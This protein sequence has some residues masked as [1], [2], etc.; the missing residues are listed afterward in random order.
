MLQAAEIRKDAVDDI[1]ASRAQFEQDAYNRYMDDLALKRD[2]YDIARGRMVDDYSLRSGVNASDKQDFYNAQEFDRAMQATD[3]ELE[4]ARF[5]DEIYRT[6]APGYAE[7]EYGDAV[8]NYK[9]SEQ[10]APILAQLEVSNELMRFV[11][12]RE[13]LRA[14]LVQSGYTSSQ[15]DAVMNEVDAYNYY[16]NG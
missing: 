15:I 7:M 13:S 3:E 5:E 6:Y 2:K 16:I 1:Y 10:F 9:I 4:R 8:R 11:S 14:A 12:D